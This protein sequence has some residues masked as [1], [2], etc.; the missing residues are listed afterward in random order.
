MHPRTTALAVVLALVLV[1]GCTGSPGG[2]DLSSD[3]DV[4][5][6]NQAGPVE[7]FERL[8]VTVSAVTFVPGERASGDPNTP[9]NESA[10]ERFERR[11]DR[12]TVDLTTV[13]GDSAAF[14]DTIRLPVRERYTTVVLS[15]SVEEATLASGEPVEVVVPNGTVDVRTAFPV[16]TGSNTTLLVDMAVTEGENSTYTL[17]SSGAA[18]GVNLTTSTPETP[19]DGSSPNGTST[20]ASTPSETPASTGTATSAATATPTP[21]EAEG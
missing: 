16:E 15:L 2:R 17:T 19:S 1:A 20:T 14:V 12:T 8:T 6:G 10:P 21:T 7:G 3:V 5:V 13:G 18:T 11:V 4:Y 9:S